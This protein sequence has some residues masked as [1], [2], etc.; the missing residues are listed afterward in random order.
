MTNVDI[1]GLC[2]DMEWVEHLRG[3]ILARLFE[4]SCIRQEIPPSFFRP[5]W[6]AC[7]QLMSDEEDDGDDMRATAISALHITMHLLRDH[8]NSGT[9]HA[10]FINDPEGMYMAV[11][12]SADASPCFNACYHF[13]HVLGSP[14]VAI[15]MGEEVFS[16]QEQH[17][18][19]VNGA[20]RVLGLFPLREGHYVGMYNDMSA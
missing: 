11:L 2:R 4:L 1:R 16:N 10:D 9:Q 6:M 7:M 17:M 15:L 18:Q 12:M 20:M 13:C 3:N 19:E 8:V 5:V 14:E